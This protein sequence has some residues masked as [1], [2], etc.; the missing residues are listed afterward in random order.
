MTYE[1]ILSTDAIADLEDA[2]DWYEEK[3]SD[4]AL[5]FL[6]SYQ[7][8]INLLKNNPFLYAKVYSN[9]RKALMKKFPYAIY[10]RMLDS[11]PKTVEVIAVFH[12]S[13]NPK[14]WKKRFNLIEE[15]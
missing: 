2:V 6:L 4:L 11:Q 1:L 7:E 3:R 9:L 10:Y 14:I 8:A 5:D 15:E 13:R 12:T